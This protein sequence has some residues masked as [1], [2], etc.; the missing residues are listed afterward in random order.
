MRVFRCLRPWT[1]VWKLVAN[2]RTKVKGANVDARARELFGSAAS[3]DLPD[4]VPHASIPKLTR[5]QPSSH[6][7]EVPGDRTDV[8]SPNL[9]YGQVS[10]SAR[11]SDVPGGGDKAQEMLC[12]RPVE[13][14][15][16]SGGVKVLA[17]HA[18]VPESGIGPYLGGNWSKGPIQHKDPAL[19]GG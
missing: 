10:Q 2:R 13:T 11:L 19:S 14:R 18:T 8:E 4:H 5:D 17:L 1:E 15:Q 16:H 3:V 12:S 7:A 9:H 6:R